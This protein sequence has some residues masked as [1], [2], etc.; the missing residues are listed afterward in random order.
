LFDIV[1]VSFPRSW[2][3]SEKEAVRDDTKG[4][5]SVE[6]FTYEDILLDVKVGRSSPAQLRKFARF[7]FANTGMV[8][9]ERRA[10][11][12]TFRSLEY[13][14]RLRVFS[15]GYMIDNLPRVVTTY[16]VE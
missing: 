13:H 2:R 15:E 6:I 9:E 8:W 11:V 7:V 4:D 1:V 12:A 5:G 10:G 16:A 14:V 3:D